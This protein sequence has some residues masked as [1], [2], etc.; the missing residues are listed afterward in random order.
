MLTMVL[1][2]AVLAFPS[3]AL[4]WEYRQGPPKVEASAWTVS[5]LPDRKP[6][7]EGERTLTLYTAGGYC[8]G[9]PPPQIDHVK[10]IERPKTEERPYKSAVIT[11]FLLHPAPSEVVG[12]VQPGEPVPACAGLGWNGTKRIKLK[13]PV[14]DLRLYD[15]SAD[16]PRLRWPPGR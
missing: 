13:R 3:T 5:L 1:A 15:G 7:I 16:P 4:G 11:V 14:R 10:V 6:A 2:F 8:I 9:E 12:E